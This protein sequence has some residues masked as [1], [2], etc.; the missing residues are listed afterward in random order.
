MPTNIPEAPEL[1]IPHYKE[2]N[3]KYW[4]PVVSAIKGFH[5]S[6]IVAVGFSL[7]VQMIRGEEEE[8]VK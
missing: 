2:Q 8:R 5:C 3:K 1:G 7:I 6:M 4:F